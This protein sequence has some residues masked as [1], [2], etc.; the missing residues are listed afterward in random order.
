MR[1]KGCK[2]PIKM[3]RKWE[4]ALVKGCKNAIEMVRKWELG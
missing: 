4:L 3:L 2:N 1:S